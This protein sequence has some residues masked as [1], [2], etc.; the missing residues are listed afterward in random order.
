M[1]LSVPAEILSIQGEMARASVGGAVR[2]ISLQMVENVKPGDFV[3]V[4]TGFAIEKIGKEEAAETL[5]MLRQLGETD[6]PEPE[7]G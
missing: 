2:E 6:L 5:E 1:C 4:H 7:I 3:L